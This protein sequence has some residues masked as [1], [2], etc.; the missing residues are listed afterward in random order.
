MW[1]ACCG[2][3]HG[4]ARSLVRSNRGNRG[5]CSGIHAFLLVQHDG[6][7]RDIGERSDAVLKAIPGH[8]NLD[9]VQT[10]KLIS[11]K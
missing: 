9:Y 6:D 3:Q 4:E 7:G 10:R 11:V 5:S 2:C 8:D 1:E